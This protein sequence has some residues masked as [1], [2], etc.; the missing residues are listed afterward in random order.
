MH[1]E[2]RKEVESSSPDGEVGPWGMSLLL[3]RRQGGAS[4]PSAAEV[5]SWRGTEGFIKISQGRHGPHQAPAS[6]H[7]LPATAE[8]GPRPM[9]VLWAS[10]WQEGA[11]WQEVWVG[12]GMGCPEQVQGVEAFSTAPNTGSAAALPPAVATAPLPRAPPLSGQ[13]SGQEDHEDDEEDDEDEEDF[14]HE[15]PVGSD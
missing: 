13:G 8:S 14:D 15:P 4:P 11:G 12:S 1:S 7:S 9:C 3:L 6:S 10:G 5:S 2:E